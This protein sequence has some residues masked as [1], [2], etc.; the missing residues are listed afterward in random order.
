MSESLYPRHASGPVP[1]VIPP[2]ESSGDCVACGRRC[3]GGPF[4]VHFI[5]GTLVARYFHLDCAPID[6][7]AEAP[8]G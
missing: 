2:G 6:D 3:F 8:L 1:V 7:R 5:K 4:V